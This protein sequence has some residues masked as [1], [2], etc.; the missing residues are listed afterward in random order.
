VKPGK[1]LGIFKKGSKAASKYKGKKGEPAGKWPSGV[2]VG[3]YGHTNSGKT[4]YF[5]V[6]NEECKIGRDLQLSI[7]DNATAG[8]ILA[9]YRSLWGVETETGVGTVVDTRGERSFPEQTT[10]DKVLLFSAIIDGEKKMPIVTYDYSGK[11]VS[12]NETGEAKDQINDFMTGCDGIL[13]FFDPKVLAAELETKAHVSSFVGILEQLVPLRKRIPIPIALVITKSDILPGFTG[14]D[15]TVLVRPEEENLLSENFDYFLEKILSANRIASDS[16]W[17]GSVRNTLVKLREFLKVVIGRTLNFQIFFTS[18]TGKEPEKIG[19]DVGRSIYAPPNR[20]R[21]VGIKE[22]FYWLLKSIRRNK[23]ISKTKKL[24]RFVVTISIIWMFLYSL[25]F[26]YHLKFLL[27]RTT[28]I[29]DNVLHTLNGNFYNTSEK[30]RRSIINA[31]RIYERSWVVKTLFPLFKNPSERI[32]SKYE[33]FDIG[34][35]GKRLE[36]SIRRFTVMVKDTALWPKLNPSDGS[37]I[38]SVDHTKLLEELNGYHVG[39]ESTILFKRSGRILVY[40]DL[41]TKSILSPSD[42]MAWE[43]IRLQVQQDQNLYASELSGAEKNLGKALNEGQVKK[44]TKAVAEKVSVE[45][46]DVIDRIN[47]N[48]SAAFRLGKGVTD[49]QKV[50]GQLD[51]ATDQAN[52]AMIDRYLADAGKFEKRQKFTMKINAL[53]DKDHVHIEVTRKGE[54]PKWAEFSQIF[55]GDEVTVN[56]KI[57]DEIHVAY[58]T[59]DIAESWGKESSDKRIFKGKYAIFDVSGDISFGNIGK[60]INISFTPPLEDM[61][62]VLE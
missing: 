31:Y 27:P 56:W 35:A 52:V 19:T 51:P 53:P 4:V 21:P 8:E 59:K 28:M 48:T 57:G 15:R 38:Q 50:R 26:L 10:Q 58:D 29:E 44:V 5:T 13:F 33:Q 23:G 24:A 16:A 54:D 55:E 11:A 40:W 17:A 34:E 42:T 2:R 14:E 37:L 30:D 36:E 60:T 39:D 49:L 7:T 45:F 20:I 18:S 12:I 46:D 47:G 61:L 9:N 3:I 6:L 32:R 25:P 41:F 62:P 43:T 22:P 1:I